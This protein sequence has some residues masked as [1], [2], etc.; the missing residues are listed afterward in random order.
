MDSTLDPDGAIPLNA[1]LNDGPPLP[2]FMISEIRSRDGPE[3]SIIKTTRGEVH[4]S[5]NGTGNK[6][7][8]F[9]NSMI[10]PTPIDPIQ[11]P[12]PGISINP[13]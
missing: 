13:R 10:L 9:E 2:L 8:D 5:S 11:T 6:T 4:L 7:A 12:Y 1:T 3:N